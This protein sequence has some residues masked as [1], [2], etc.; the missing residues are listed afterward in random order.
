MY[1]RCVLVSVSHV[2]SCV[3]LCV[4][5]GY[6]CVGARTSYL[7]S[8]RK[9]IPS[10]L[11]ALE[12]PISARRVRTSHLGLARKNVPSRL[13]VNTRSTPDRIFL[14]EMVLSYAP[15]RY[16]TFLRAEPR[17]DVLTRRGE[18]GCFYAPSRNRSFLLPPDDMW[19]VSGCPCMY[20]C[21]CVCA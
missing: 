10:R 20:A 12:R 21:V 2:R 9:N 3:R 13:K 8:V 15:N 7:G 1:R 14:P 16:G 6:A 18:M 11:G 19:C 5:V 17:W 4:P